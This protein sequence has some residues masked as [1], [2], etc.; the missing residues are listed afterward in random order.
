M[1]SSEFAG[2][3]GRIL[4][5]AQE[6]RA[7]HSC[8]YKTG[9][10]LGQGSYAVVKEAVHIETGRKYAAKIINKRLMSG[11]ERMVRN[12][13]QVLKRVSQGHANILT[14]V[15]YFE[16]A[17]NLYL[18]TSIAHGGELFDHVLSKGSYYESDAVRILRQ[19]LSGMA[20][21][22]ANG[23]VHRDLKPENILFRTADSDADVLIADFG[24]S[25]IIDD[26]KLHM[27]KT[28]CGTPGYM[29]P[30]MVKKTG[31]GKPVDIW[32]LGIIA[33]FLLSGYLPFDRDSPAEEMEAILAG[34]VVFDP[35][36][37]WAEISADAK[38]FIVRCLMADPAA[39]LTVDECAAHAFIS[40][41]SGAA[42]GDETDLLPGMRTN[43]NARRSHHSQLETRLLTRLTDG[44]IMDGR[45]TYSPEADK[46][47]LLPLD[48]ALE[49]AGR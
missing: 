40:G 16:T 31:H 15:D 8:K 9:R 6:S 45:F 20:Y 41:A 17:N 38:D 34:D 49:G 1:Q 39:R 46:S 3:P 35:E 37:H 24:M 23:I 19:I 29:A 10:T 22:H 44:A 42:A 5:E 4:A 12:E 48:A 30:E 11:R 13:V 43:Y 32:G 2:G 7:I 18:V 36:E 33:Y 14:M 28:M 21:L 25:Q 47:P 26:E 27:L